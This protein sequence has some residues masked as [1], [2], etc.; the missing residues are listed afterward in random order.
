MHLHHLLHELHLFILRQFQFG[1]YFRYHAGAYHF[2]PVKGPAMPF[3]KTLGRRLGNI[4]Q[5]SR[6]S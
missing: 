2:M 1:E 5:D 6:P 4:M 3:F